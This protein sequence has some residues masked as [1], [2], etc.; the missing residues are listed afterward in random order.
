VNGHQVRHKKI[1]EAV[2]EAL[3]TTYGFV[4]AAVLEDIVADAIAKVITYQAHHEYFV[5]QQAVK[6]GYTAKDAA[7][8]V[9]V[10]HAPIGGA[11][12]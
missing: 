6:A 7:D 1:Y 2:G 5:R 4:P 11:A 9:A 12:A 3:L 8:M 10:L